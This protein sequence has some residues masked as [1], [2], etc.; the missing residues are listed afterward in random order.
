[1]KLNKKY[2]DF[3]ELR[4][5]V[6]RIISES[7]ENEKTPILTIPK[8]HE[9][10]HGTVEKFDAS[11]IRPGSYD[12]VFWTTEYPAISQS[13][14]PVASSTIY[15]NSELIARPSINE[16]VISRQK[17]LGIVYSD[18]SGDERRITSYKEAPVFKQ[19][20]DNY[21]KIFDSL[22]KAEE[23]YKLFKKELEKTLPTATKEDRNLLLKK[24]MEY[25]SIIEKLVRDYNKNKPEKYKNEYVNKKLVELGYKPYAEDN[26][27]SNHNWKLKISGLGKNSKILPAEHRAEGRLLIVIPKEDL[28]IFDYTLGGSTEGDL[29]DLDYHKISLFDKVRESGYDGIKINDFAQIESEGNFGHYSIGL[30]KN[31]LRK[32]SIQEIPATHPKDFGERHYKAN[33]YKTPEYRQWKN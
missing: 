31:A 11:T 24:D 15:T 7:Q 20:S 19:S 27:N 1:M 29:T 9:L 23:E 2:I 30:F 8:G 14:I 17:Q 22:F 13:Y 4:K 28:K 18:V 5:V 21:Y 3:S 25:K 10:F 6:R 16:E 26:F 12:S 32:V 33:D